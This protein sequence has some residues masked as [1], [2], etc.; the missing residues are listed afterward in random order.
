MKR[1]LVLAL[2]LFLSIPA[3]AE[4]A[5]GLWWVSHGDG[6]PLQVRLYPDGSAWS[7]YPS[8]NPGRWRHQGDSVT[9]LWADDW[10]ERFVSSGRG[11]EKWGYKPGTALESAPTNKSRAYRVSESPDGWFGP[12]VKE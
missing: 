6:A 2:A 11:W 10:K 8:N 3:L 7:D 9:C 4:P 12:A 5:V 1:Q